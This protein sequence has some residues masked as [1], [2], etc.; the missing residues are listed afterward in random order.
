VAAKLGYIILKAGN[1][2]EC[3]SKR[4]ALEG[5]CASGRGSNMGIEKIS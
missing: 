4:D 5:V 1:K 3:V 2:I